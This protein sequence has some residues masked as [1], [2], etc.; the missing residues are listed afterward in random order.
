MSDALN[1]PGLR[2]ALME[3]GRARSAAIGAARREL[4]IGEGDAT[5]LLHIADN[6]GI[7]PTQ[8][9]EHLG[10]TAAG[11]TA[12]IDRLV[13]RGAVR[14][15]VDPSDRRV[16]RI[17]LTID[18][19]QEPWVALTRFDDDFDEAVLT[20]DEGEVLR[21]A[22]LLGSLTSVVVDRAAR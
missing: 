2:H 6:P 15:D 1:M 5:A 14:R 9:R 10:I 16:N 22:E 7:R 3:Y 12:L 13:D 18:L 8:L 4:G 11:I 19:G 21:F 20:A 17:S